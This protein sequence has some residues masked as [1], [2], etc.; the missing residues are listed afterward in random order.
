MAELE[1]TGW[2]PTQR[3]GLSF[4]LDDAQIPSEWGLSSVSVPEAS[5]DQA[6]RFI[7]FLTDTSGD[8]RFEHA[9]PPDR[10]DDAWI[11][12]TAPGPFT[13]DLGFP[14]VATPGLRLGGALIDG[15]LLSLAGALVLVLSGHTSVWNQV[16]LL[17]VY[18]IGM[19]GLLG[20]T[21]GNMAVRTRVV[22]VADRG[23]PG[24]RA[25]FIRW[26][27]PQVGWLIALAL[28]WPGALSF[29]WSLVVYIPVLVGPTYRGLHDR[30]SGVIVLDDRLTTIVV[31]LPEREPDHP[32]PD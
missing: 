11:R 15:V 6:Q 19:V 27:V 28:S 31:E 32:G 9:D 16:T 12:A 26:L 1:I 17:A 30:A 23:A 20:R 4:L 8:I 21:V 10:N 13:E 3:E 24:V 2:T 29:V 22:S 7:A 25:A 14:G 18:Q 5:R